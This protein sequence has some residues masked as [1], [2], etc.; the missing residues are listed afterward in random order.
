M[1]VLKNI[2]VADRIKKSSSFVLISLV[3]FVLV[4]FVSDWFV[5]HYLMHLKW[6]RWTMYEGFAS[7]SLWLFG[8]GSMGYRYRSNT[9]CHSVTLF[10]LMVF[11]LYLLVV[12]PI[13]LVLFS[14]FKRHFVILKWYFK[15]FAQVFGYGKDNLLGYWLW[16]WLYLWLLAGAGKIILQRTRLT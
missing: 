15:D 3:L 5:T 10:A 6:V 2:L 1:D 7:P 13:E 12:T 14:E 8:M 9:K 16:Q 4:G 11:L